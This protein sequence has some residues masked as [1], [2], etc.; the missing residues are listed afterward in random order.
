MWRRSCP[1]GSHGF[2]CMRTRKKQFILSTFSVTLLKGKPVIC[3]KINVWIYFFFKEMYMYVSLHVCI[4]GMWQFSV[5]M[6][7]FRWRRLSVT[8]LIGLQIIWF[9]SSKACKVRMLA[10]GARSHQHCWTVLQC[11]C[12]DLPSVLWLLF[13]WCA[14]KKSAVLCAMMCCNTLQLH[15]HIRI[16]LKLNKIK[17][18]VHTNTRAVYNNAHAVVWANAF[19]LSI[20]TQ[21]AFVKQLAFM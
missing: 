8:W 15:Y 5:V 11:E 18:H 1:I 21:L 4:L 9:I 7:A 12:G 2:H 10:S 6:G 14:L 13:H 19:F 3:W 16:T 17:R 20:V